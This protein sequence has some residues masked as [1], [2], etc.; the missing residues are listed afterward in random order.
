MV[1]LQFT[2]CMASIAP[3]P[4]MMECCVKMKCPTANM[5]AE[6]CKAMISTTAPAALVTGKAV[7]H[8]PALAAILIAPMPNAVQH[9]S[10]LPVVIMAQ[11]H[12]PPDLNTL[13]HSFL[14]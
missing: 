13:H 7:V 1:F 3:K 9:R 11:Q 14:I 8:I 5:Q 2:D 12:S 10:V 6:C 4:K